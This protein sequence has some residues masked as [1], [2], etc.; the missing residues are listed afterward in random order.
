MKRTS[1]LLRNRAYARRNVSTPAPGVQPVGS[2]DALPV[3]DPATLARRAALID[4]A[5]DADHDFLPL[6]RAKGHWLVGDW[7]SLCELSDSQIARHPARDRLAL[8]VACANLQLN[9]RERG[10]SLLR[11]A[12]AW[13]CNPQLAARLLVS[14]VHNS[15]GR[16]AALRRDGANTDRHFRQAMSLTGDPDAQ[17]A[18]QSRAVREMSR[19]GLLDQATALLG[20]RGE[21]LASHAHQRPLATD[22]AFS[23][24]RGELQM[25]QQELALAQRRQID[26]ALEARKRNAEVASA[27]PG[28]VA[29]SLQQAST[30]QL[31]QDLWVIDRTRGKVGGYFVEFGATDGIRLSNTYL[32]ETA[33]QWNG[34]CA[35]PNPRYF[36][37]LQ[38][39]RRC[40]VSQACVGPT[41]GEWV[42]FVL[43]EEFGG[44]T[45]HMARDMHAARRAAYW[46]DESNRLR[47]QT[48]SLH[49]LLVQHRA[50][51]DIDY[52]SI[53]TEGSELAILSQFPLDQWNVRLITV[54]HNFSEDRE[55]IRRLL[56][57][58]GYRRTES[59]WDDWYEKAA[60]TDNP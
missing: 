11:S 2:A 27:G 35:E 12:L 18:A 32:L 14:G 53:D 5:A 42:D 50:P 36:A 17:P 1:R 30:S 38:R 22:E 41:T 43:A 13:G 28:T 20:R 57:D 40:A 24:L 51:H 47:L 49:D 29:D 60:V 31:G 8:L 37:Q 33:L 52:L 21:E 3:T 23:T 26:A 44:M 55:G 58:H 25:L 15:L 6:A 59:Q 46:A 7:S 16:A 45:A 54:E 4:P 39:N 48:V 34:L 9:Q 56:E 10:E 19:L